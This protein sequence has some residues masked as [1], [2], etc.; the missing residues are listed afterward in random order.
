MTDL[1]KEK[2][3]FG[4]LHIPTN[5]ILRTYLYDDEDENKIDDHGEAVLFDT[6]ELAEMAFVFCSVNAMEKKRGR[7]TDKEAHFL[8]DIAYHDSISIKSLMPTKVL[9]DNLFS[10]KMLAFQQKGQNVVTEY[11]W[12]AKDAHHFMSKFSLV[13]CL[14]LPDNIFYEASGLDRNEW[15][16]NH[17][18]KKTGYDLNRYEVYP[19]TE[20]EIVEVLKGIQIKRPSADEFKGLVMQIL[21]DSRVPQEIADRVKQYIKD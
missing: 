9:R 18:K 19:K 6:K 13:E 15:K 20:F 2:T 1:L 7:L 4:I 8:E 12:T 5:L 16:Y 11:E 14:S 3:K 17:F 10:Y 21:K